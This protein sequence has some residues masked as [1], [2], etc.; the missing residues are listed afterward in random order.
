MLKQA[1]TKEVV[2]VWIELNEICSVWSPVVGFCWG[3]DNSS[4][5]AVS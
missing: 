4:V 1:L 3:G 2:C 5:L